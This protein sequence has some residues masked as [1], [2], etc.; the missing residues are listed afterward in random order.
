MF[1]KPKINVEI[2]YENNDTKTVRK[3]IKENKVIIRKGHKGRGLTS[4]TP[5]FSK[6]CIIE[7]ESGSF[8]FKK[9]R[10]TLVV[11]DG[12][13]HCVD[14]TCTP[15]PDLKGLTRNDVEEMANLDSIRKSGAMKIKHE[16]PFV[17]W[18]SRRR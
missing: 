18:V 14:F 4:W 11:K 13:E 8:P 2:L 16:L 7:R 12:S 5:V 9:K 3:P 1:K 15:D 17:F 6:G 10:K